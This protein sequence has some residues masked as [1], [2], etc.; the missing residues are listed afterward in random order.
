MF[1]CKCTKILMSTSTQITHTYKSQI[2]IEN[3]DKSQIKEYSAEIH[4]DRL[5]HY[6]KSAPNT[7]KF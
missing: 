3:C 4:N 7:T 6:I 5:G 1:A 2:I